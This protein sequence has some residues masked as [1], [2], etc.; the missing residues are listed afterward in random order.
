MGFI[1]YLMITKNSSNNLKRFYNICRCWICIFEKDS[2]NFTMNWKIKAILQ[3]VL[4][5]T[6]V[7]DILNHKHITL[8]KN[9]HRNVTVYQTH[10]ALRRFRMAGISNDNLQSVLEIGTGYS[11]ISALVFA[12]LGFKKIVTADVSKDISFKV[13]RKQFLAL[14]P[15]C[16]NQIMAESALSRGEIHDILEQVK[17]QR[18]LKGIL[19]ALNIVYLAPYT[20]E[21]IG[22][23]C[24]K[25][26]FIT[27][28][29]V[30]EHIPPDFLRAIFE[31]SKLWLSASGCCVHT[32]NFVDH[33]A[34]PG[35]FED[36]SISLFNFLKYSDKQW[37]YWA[38]NPIAYTNRLAYP[39][40]IDLCRRVGFEKIFF[41]GENYREVK[42]LSANEVHSDVFQKYEIAISADELMLY[43]RGTLICR[44]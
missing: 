39:F 33:F 21:E 38:G 28:Q 31:K 12:L 17:T 15:D 6:R 22:Q 32:I 13:F 18:N 7:G 19:S 36:Q 4:S 30:F 29:V 43:Q 27:S 5:K 42:I 20:L 37:K 2:R 26:S 11:L 3:K 10:E 8:T 14:D 34:N 40:Y 1:N 35:I 23:H 25:Y 16:I 9:Y 41:F 24:S 44:H